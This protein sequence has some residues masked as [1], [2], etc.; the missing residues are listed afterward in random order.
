MLTLSDET[1]FQAQRR[2]KQMPRYPGTIAVLSLGLSLLFFAPPLVAQS[3]KTA[4]AAGTST[5]LSPEKAISLA[6]QGR[7]KEAVPALKRA[8][9]SEGSAD[10]MKQAGVLGLRCSLTLDNRDSTL[11]F[12][13][14]LRKQF[15]QDPDVLFILVHAY[16]DLSSRTAQ[17]L[18]RT[19]PQSIP[20]HKLNAEA[21][22]MQGKWDEA[23]REYEEMIAKEPNTTGLH[24]LFGR[25]LLSRPDADAKAAERAKQE[26]QKE[27]EIDPKNAGAQYI[28]GE[29]ARR[30][31]NWDEAIARFSAAAKL[32]PNFAEAYLGWGFSLVTVKRYEEAIAPLR[33]A[34][35]LTPGNPA[36]HYSLATALSRTGKKEDAEKEFAIHRGLTSPTPTSP[37]AEKPQ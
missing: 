9:T 21:L 25:L 22:E 28:L 35:R 26:F 34:E 3:R 8:L 37:A 16:S 10:T 23:Q 30:D 19:A 7:C 29:M 32:D 1:C 13:R 20:A 12:I 24:F 5:A 33:V 11:D 2:Q 18:G 14:L 31:E 15:G 17:D 4:P 36:V 27:I 6:Q